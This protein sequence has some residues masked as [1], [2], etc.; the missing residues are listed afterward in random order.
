[1]WNNT[2]P[3]SLAISRASWA[4]LRSLAMLF[5]LER[6]AGGSQD[7]KELLDGTLVATTGAVWR[8][9]MVWCRVE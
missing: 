7:A 1:M 4:S 6:L 2:S 3:L 9:S 5:F 8:G